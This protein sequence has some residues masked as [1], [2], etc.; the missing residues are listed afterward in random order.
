MLAEQLTLPLA[1]NR[2]PSR[3]TSTV[4]VLVVEDDT[5]LRDTVVT[6]VTLM[7]FEVLEA[8]DTDIALDIIESD[9]AIDLLFSDVITPGRRTGVELAEQALARRPELKVILTTG[10]DDDPD[11][12]VDHFSPWPVLFKPYQR[13]ELVRAFD[14]I[15]GVEK[16]DKP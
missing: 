14:T 10:Y 3:D 15:L 9:V 6:L 13:D 16:S 5:D 2:M 11:R 12:I 7:G 4:S 8:S 1:T